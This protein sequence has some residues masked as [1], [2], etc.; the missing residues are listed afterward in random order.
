MNEY[1]LIGIP[2]KGHTQSILCFD[3][4]KDLKYLVSA[5]RD[6]LLIIYDV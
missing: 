3:V 1:I 5:A 2:F 4:S 6:N